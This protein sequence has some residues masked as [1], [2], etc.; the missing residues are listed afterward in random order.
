MLDTPACPDIGAL[1]LTTPPPPPHHVL[2]K[3]STA[4]RVTPATDIH[5]CEVHQECRGGAQVGG[6][7]QDAVHRAH[8]GQNSGIPQTEQVERPLLTDDVQEP[9]QN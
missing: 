1:L 7:E 5:R 9:L 3:A 2:A 6:Q 4:D 8:E